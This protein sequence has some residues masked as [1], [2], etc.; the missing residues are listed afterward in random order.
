MSGLTLTLSAPAVVARA[1]IGTR[2][3]G[4]WQF[5]RIE[6]LPDGTLHAWYH[7]NRDSALAY[8]KPCGHALSRDGG[9]S[10][11]EAEPPASGGL[12]A[13][14]GERVRPFA[15]ESLPSG[16]VELGAKLGSLVNYG[17]PLDFYDAR[18]FPPELAGWGLERL[19]P[20]S[21]RWARETPE[22]RIPGEVRTVAEGVLTFPMFW[23]LRR[24][25]DGAL[26]GPSY[27]PR[28]VD[29]ELERFFGARFLRSADGGRHWDLYS[30]IPY[31]PEA[32]APAGA[33]PMAARRLGFT[34]PDVAFLTGGAALCLLR[35]TDGNGIGPC[36]AA[37]SRDGGRTWTAPRRFDTRGVWPTLLVL[38]SGAVLAGY[39]RP[40]LFLRP[41]RAD[42]I[43][44]STGGI[45]GWE[46]P[47]ALVEPGEYQT[48]TCSYLDMAAL[49]RSTA[50]VV[51]SDFRYPD[52]SGRPRKT[53]LARRAS[54]T[55]PEPARSPRRP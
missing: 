49:D 20:G 44:G 47:V 42:A 9:A 24:A 14:G 28:I 32:L 21:G 36:Y 10:W 45:E 54:I 41:G 12:E 51:Y 29:G 13:G 46:D 26:W 18:G 37:L 38:E 53:I 15:R 43:A 31:A 35:T 23:R 1:P 34:E 6:L 5:P 17:H 2:E 7:V 48:E 40:G 27:F 30:E 33:D 22:V 19:A 39:G 11:V 4:F 25:P 55:W 3:W 8:G 52:E 50:L 16:G